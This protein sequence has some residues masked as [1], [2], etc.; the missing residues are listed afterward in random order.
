[1]GAYLLL[2]FHGDN[3]RLAY[4]VSLEVAKLAVSTQCLPPIFWSHWLAC[5][6]IPPTG[7]SDGDRAAWL[8]SCCGS[9]RLI[10]LG[11]DTSAA[12]LAGTKIWLSKDALP[13]EAKRV[14]LSIA[15]KLLGPLLVDF[16]G[17]LETG[18]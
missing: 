15:E 18:D 2:Y 1:M 14:K 13:G 16:N 10:L 3:Y 11:M 6:I 9:G 4:R 7:F 17:S 12:S 5:M 8:G